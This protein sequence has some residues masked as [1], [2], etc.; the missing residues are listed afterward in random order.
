[1]SWL[2]RLLGRQS[3]PLPVPPPAPRLSGR[4]L[5]GGRVS[6]D[7]SDDYFLGIPFVDTTLDAN[8]QWATLDLDSKTLLRASPNEVMDLLLDISPEISRALWDFLRMCN[9]GWTKKVKRPGSDTPHV[10]GEATLSTFF[11]QLKTLYGSPDLVFG[12][13]FFGGFLSGAFCGEL[14]LD[15]RGRLPVDIAT[16]DARSIRFQKESDPVRGTVWTPVQLQGGQWVRLDI[17]TFKYLPIDPRPGNPYGRPIANPAIFVA[18]FL[19]ALLHDIKR[20]VQQQG[21]PRLDIEVLLE[22]IV[23]AFPTLQAQPERLQDFAQNILNTVISEYADLEPDDTYV[24]TSAVKV[25]R[26]VGAIDTSSIGAIDGVVQLLERQAVRALKTM[27]LLMGITDGVSEA[28]ANRQ[29][30]IHAAG[31]KSLQHLAEALLEHFFELALQA[32]GIQADVEFRFAELRAAEELRDQQT[33]QLKITNYQALV[34]GGY[35]DREEASQE[36][37]GHPPAKSD[38]DLQREA[39]EAFQ[40]QQQAMADAA[41]Q[42][43]QDQ[44]AQPGDGQEQTPPDNADP[45]AQRMTPTDFRRLLDLLEGHADET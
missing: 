24:H 31:I 23:A 8:D 20:V 18:V 42:N 32:Q 43:G 2:D 26:P 13:L 44:G 12:R 1:M 38:E 28:N 25:N 22:S 41:Q 17:P 34:D 36:L 19:I 21:Y 29:W 9:P 30:E 16:P 4:A 33:L 37:V 3:P 11:D 10:Q 7:K 40:K 45:G 6:L 39:E 15:K 14:I 5:A 35:V 27:P